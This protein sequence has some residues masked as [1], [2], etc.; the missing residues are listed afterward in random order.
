MPSNVSQMG[1]L[2]NTQNFPFQRFDVCIM[3]VDNATH[4]IL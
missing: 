1:H 4:G 3:Y 2:L